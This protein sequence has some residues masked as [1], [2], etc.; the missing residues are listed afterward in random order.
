MNKELSPEQHSLQILKKRALNLAKPFEKSEQ[1]NK[2]TEIVE[3]RMDI[4]KYGFETLFVSEV[5]PL[6]QLTPLPNVPA[7]IL[8]LVNIRRRILSVIDLKA[9]F[10]LPSKADSS[11]FAIILENPQMEFAIAADDICGI[12]TLYP[13]DE[14][15]LE[16]TKYHQRQ[17]LIKCITKDFLIILDANKILAEK[18]LYFDE[19]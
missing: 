7:F 17:D 3:F 5:F 11:K 19:K 10:G 15:L 2:K 14:L 9:Y 8:G 1:I 6:N 4:E 18:S 16:K 13:Q 12:R